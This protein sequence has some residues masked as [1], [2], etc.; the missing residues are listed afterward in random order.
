MKRSALAGGQGGLTLMELLMAAGV[1]ILLTASAGFLFI[2]QVRGYK[3]IGA[4][5]KLQTMSK[6]AVQSMNTEIA[7]TGACLANKRLKFIM[8]PNQFQFAYVDLKSRH[9]SNVD[10]VIISYYVRAGTTSDT[11]IAKTQCNSGKAVYSPLIKGLGK[12]TIAFTYYDVNGAATATAS[13]VKAVEFSLDVKS[14]AGKSLFVKDRNP[15]VR[16]EL[17]N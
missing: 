4:Q 15:K 1:G 16:V 3:D 12:I 6:T 13:K 8:L 7:N 2:G 5:A 11:L 14:Q 17:L 9:C 10:T